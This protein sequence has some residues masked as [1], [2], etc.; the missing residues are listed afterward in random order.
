MDRVSRCLSGQARLSR[1]VLARCGQDR[2]ERTTSRG[3]TKSQLT[4]LWAETLLRVGRKWGWVGIPSE[5]RAWDPQ[6]SGRV[7]LTLFCLLGL[8][9]KARQTHF[10][11][12]GDFPL[13]SLPPASERHGNLFKSFANRNLKRPETCPQGDIP[14]EKEEAIE[15]LLENFI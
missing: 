15:G 2:R 5:S 7:W 8:N 9:R 14:G 10:G 11:N 1:P 13:Q 4:W 12:A 6:G 3:G